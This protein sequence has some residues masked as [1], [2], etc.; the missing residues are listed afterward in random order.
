M[1]AMGL[2][3]FA[4]VVRCEEATKVSV[5]Q[6]KDNPPAFNHKL[7]EVTGFVSHGFEDFSVFDPACDSWPNIWLEYG[8]RVKS[9]TM[10]CC[11]VTAERTRIQELEIEDTSVPLLNDDEFQ[12]FDTL[13]QIRP[14]SLVHATMIGRFFAGKERKFPK[15][16]IWGGYGH[17][18]CCSLLAIQQVVSVDP[19]NL[20]DV[21]Y[22]T[23]ADQPK[24]GDVGCGFRFLMPPSYRGLEAWVK[25][26]KNAELGEAEWAFENPERV[27]L[28]T[29]AQLAK[30]ALTQV[31]GM[32][33]T[34]AAQGRIVYEW[35]PSG[36]N[37]HYMVVVSRPY[38]LSF[39]AKDASKIAWV[40]AAAY[41]SYCDKK[42][43]T[44]RIK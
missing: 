7:V 10:Y 14:S 27:A 38:L 9:G 17:M 6:L 41:E 35:I 15:E 29:L 36:K 26:Q 8:G 4:G 28:E 13:I 12:R 23:Q 32:K 37:M 22:G 44:K 2:L 5:C 1:V 16:T 39:Y 19:H 11:G 25:T 33:Q 3:C 21:D 31:T 42:N 30:V 40:V 18:G 43:S 20:Q 24:L 34:S